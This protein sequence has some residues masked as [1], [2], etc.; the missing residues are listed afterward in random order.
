MKHDLYIFTKN[1]ALAE[2]L[3]I[4][5]IENTQP[6]KDGSSDGGT[7]MMKLFYVHYIDYNKRLDEWVSMDRM[8]LDKLQPP[9]NSSGHGHSHSNSNSTPAISQQTTVTTAAAAGDDDDDDDKESVKSV[10]IKN[11]EISTS[12]ANSQSKKRKR[13]SRLVIHI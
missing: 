1:E 11:E 3:R 4:R 10:S 7:T 12:T 13:K 5:L 6:N 9:A 2:V 8:R